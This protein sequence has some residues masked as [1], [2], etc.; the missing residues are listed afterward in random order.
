MVPNIAPP[1]SLRFSRPAALGTTGLTPIVHARVRH[2]EHRRLLGLEEVGLDDLADE[3]RVA[4]HVDLLTYFAVDIGD[5]LLEDR[6]ARHPLDVGEAVE[7]AGGQV[8][9]DR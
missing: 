6:G 5:G 7:G 4:P 1:R 2:A 3:E 9:L 8:D